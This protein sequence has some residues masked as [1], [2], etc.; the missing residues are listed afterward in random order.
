MNAG[1]ADAAG[2]VNE[3]DGGRSGKAGMGYVLDAELGKFGRKVRSQFD[4]DGIIAYLFSVIAP[5][6]RSFVE[7][8]IG[9]AHRDVAYAG[10]LEGNCVLLREQGWTGLFMDGGLHPASFGVQREFITPLNVDRLFAKYRVPYNVDLVSIDVDG[11]DL[12]IWLALSARPSV[13]IVEYN[14]SIPFGVSKTV[15]FRMDFGWDGTQWMGAS[16]SALVKVG[17]AKGYVPVYANGVNLFFVREELVANAGDFRPETIFRPAPFD[18]RADPQE[19]PFT[20]I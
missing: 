6:S 9:P 4:E 13:L 2:R 1:C 5:R 19:R 14:G 17:A 8:G 11:Q 15:P 3:R 18:H 16:F 12:W 20:V 10:G 7:F